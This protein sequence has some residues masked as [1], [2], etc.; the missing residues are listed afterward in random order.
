MAFALDLRA[1]SADTAASTPAPVIPTAWAAATGLLV[2]LPNFSASP[3]ADGYDSQRLLELAA[4]TL[5]VVAV[6]GVPAVRASWLAVWARVPRWATALAMGTAVLGLA[7]AARAPRPVYAFTEVAMFVM[8]GIGVVTVA[9]SGRAR[10]RSGLALVAVGTLAGYALSVLPFHLADIASGEVGVW[11]FRHLGFSHMRQVNHLHVWFLP[12]VWACAAGART[13]WA[14]AGLRTV[15][16]VTVAL[17]VATFGRGILMALVAGIVVAVLAVRA[18]RVAFLREILSSAVLGLGGWVLLFAGSATVL[19]RADAGLNGRADLWAGAVR[20]VVEHPWLGVGPMHYVYAP[21]PLGAHPHN[22][23]LQLAS[24]WG[25]PAMLLMAALAL[26]AGAGWLR[27][28]HRAQTSDAAWM[29]GLTAAFAGALAYSLVDGILIAPVSQIM[30]TLVLGALVAE[31]LPASRVLLV[32]RPSWQDAS[33]RDVALAGVA[34]PALAVLLAVA[35]S[36]GPTLA[37]RPYDFRAAQVG[38]FG[39]PRFWSTGQIAGRLPPEQARRWPAPA[40]GDASP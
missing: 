9:A 34:L 20:M 24:E 18:G 11:P 1:A 35:A 2:L 17:M 23:V 6:T 39:T 32:T 33:W 21:S 3:F 19:D 28:A 31:A 10:A 7:S 13:G 36:D 15:A 5:L 26:G 25:V 16:A 40:G 38:S 14:R 27:H 37:R 4:C 22:L 30:A 29:A 8:M 12:L